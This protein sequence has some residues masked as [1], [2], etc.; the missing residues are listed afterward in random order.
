MMRLVYHRHFLKSVQRLPK[1]QQ[2]KL[3]TLLSQLRENP[4]HPLLHSK[5]LTGRL[6]GFLSFRVTRG[7]GVWSIVF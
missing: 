7:N 2:R 3:A 4:Y 1:S 5:R 6:T